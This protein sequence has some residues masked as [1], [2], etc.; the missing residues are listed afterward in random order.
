M[1]SFIPANF[2]FVLII[3]S[4]GLFF[5]NSMAKENRWEYIGEDAESNKYYYDIKNIVKKS[6]DINRVWEKRDFAK[7][8]GVALSYKASISLV[9]I[10]CGKKEARNIYEDL[11]LNSGKVF[12]FDRT[13]KPW[14]Y[15]SPETVHETLYRIVCKKV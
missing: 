3:I 4:V 15:I 6:D 10:D 14:K 7:I 11:I 9:E 8:N 12:E 5:T 1:K 13:E 2:L